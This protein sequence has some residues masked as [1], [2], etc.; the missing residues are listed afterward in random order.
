M[1]HAPG[2]IS[3]TA[4]LLIAGLHAEQFVPPGTPRGVVVVTHGY[5][6][7]CGRYHELAHVLVNAGWAAVSYDV[8]GHGQSPGVRGFIDR[9]ELYLDDLT[10]VI[11]HA[12]TLVP[13]NAPVVLLGHSHGSLITLRALAGDRPPAVQAAIV[14]SPFLG[15]KL[16]VP[17]HK[18][19]LA[20]VA[21][22]VAPKLAQ[23]NALRVED[24]TSDPEKQ[25]ARRADKLCFDVATARWFTEAAAAQA[26]V[27]THASR[28]AVPTTWL[29]AA[30]DAIADPTQSRAIAGAMKQ[31][32]YHDL[33]G[34]RHEVFNE[35]ERAQVFAH[36]T[37][38]LAS[39]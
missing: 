33:R 35:R 36:V 32:T 25:A 5:A 16:A 18:K 6:E 37:A 30:D 39:V 9:F 4:T 29:V 3:P 26:Y 27:A 7:H 24:L 10:A 34:L 17:A 31:A 1:S 28:I 11:A 2:P 15:L 19:V 22:K 14:S 12:R 20:R 38:A 8:R 21:S 13:A 23:P